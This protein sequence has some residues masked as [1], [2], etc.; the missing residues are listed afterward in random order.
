MKSVRVEVG[1]GNKARIVDTDPSAREISQNLPGRR[2]WNVGSLM[3][4]LSRANVD[5]LRANYDVDWSDRARV[6]Q[7][8]ELEQ[9]EKVAREAKLQPLP[10]E[11]FNFDFKTKPRPH[12]G[13]AFF[14]SRDRDAYGLFLEQGLGKTKVVLDTAAYQWSIGKIDTLLITAPNGVHEQWIAEQ[15]PIHLPDW[16]SYKSL[17][18]RSGG[19]KI[20]RWCEERDACLGFDGGLR[21][22]AI[23]QDAL[24]TENGIEFVRNILMGGRVLWVIDE[25][26]SIKTPGAKRTKAVL[27]LRG[28]AK[29]R[30]ILTGTP[31]TKGVENLYT[32]LRFLSDDV[33]GFTSFLSFRNRYCE[34]TPNPFAPGAVRITGYKNLDELKERMDAWAVRMTNDETL[35]IERV[36]FVRQVPLTDEQ[37]RLYKEMRTELLTQLKGGQ[38]VSA[39][40]AA[41][42]LMRL[43]QIVC[44]HIKDEHGVVHRIPSNRVSSLMDFIED[45]GDHKMVVWARFHE[46]IDMLVEAATKA[47]MLPA[48]WDGRNV[49][50]RTKEKLKFIESKDVGPFIANPGSAAFG[51]DG[52]QMVSY[53]MVWYSNSF[54][55]IERWQG[56]GRLVRDGQKHT[57]MVGDMEAPGTVDGYIRKVLKDNKDI[58]DRVLDLQ[59]S[60]I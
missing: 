51:V 43:Q 12:Q 32:Q 1:P 35:G 37:R 16:V 58:A 15:V 50:T 5:W 34:T 47:G 22:I 36:P 41:T 29:S 44:G 57:V 27:K 17:V 53:R 9:K 28:L 18:Y 4:E 6:D 49:D 52:L 60:D 54:K 26:T 31:V 55:S 30:R 19:H 33:H 48:V 39:E 11:A 23:H 42:K 20:K 21:I 8:I 10:P 13:R 25:S 45:V 56:E 24:A 14:I 40:H 38:I 59:P 46:D 3:F 7:I 2:R